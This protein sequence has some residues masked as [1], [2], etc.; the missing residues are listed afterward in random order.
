MGSFLKDLAA[1]VVV[2][3]VLF[4]LCIS[5]NWVGLSIS[6]PFQNKQT[7]IT[8]ATNQY[9]TTKQTELLTFATQYQNVMVRRVAAKGDPD[10]QTV[11]TA[12]GNAILNQIRSEAATLQPDQVPQSVAA[13]IQ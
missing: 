13:L 4:V 2:L 10:A 9:V 5:F 7:A 1:A 6:L 11:Y 8:R 3:V 12:Q